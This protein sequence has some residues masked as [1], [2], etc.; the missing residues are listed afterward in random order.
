[1]IAELHI[2][3]S[4]MITLPVLIGLV[5]ALYLY[6][7]RTFDYWQKRGVKHDKPWPLF[8]TNARN[9]LMQLSTADIATETYKKYPG[10]KIVGFYRSSRPELVIRDPALAKRILTNDFAY[11]H[12]RGIMPAD[13]QLEPLQRNMFFG[14]DDLWRLV[15]IRM[16]PAFSSGKLKAMFPLI[17]ERTERLQNR[18]RNAAD[19][20]QAINSRDLMAR[21]TTDVIGNVGFGVLSDSLNDQ[22]TAFR[23]LGSRVIALDSIRIFKLT[24]KNI[25]P[26]LFGHLTVFN[27]LQ[28][29]VVGMVTA[30]MEQRKYEPS[31]RNDFVDQLLECR[32]KGVMTGESIVEVNAD[33]SPKKVSM[34]M[35]NELIAAHC[36][37]FFIAGFETSSAATSFTLHQLAHNPDIQRKAQEEIDR[38][39]SQYDNKLCYD[40]ISEMSY[41]KWCLEEGLRMFPSVGYLQRRCVRSYRIPDTKVT[42]EPGV[43]LTI[44]LDAYQNDPAI[45][46]EPREFRPERFD[47][48]VLTPAQKN[49]FLPFGDGPRACIGM[50]SLILFFFLFLSCEA[51]VQKHLD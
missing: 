21:Y 18:L 40:A 9:Y 36:L 41:L 24:L 44:P 15:R 3:S 8:G 33:G 20:K 35:D 6:L 11:F 31:G 45:F 7:T 46:P 47:P 22:N 23:E 32:K 30:I 37:L 16:T 10:E 49:A 28:K 2:I 50:L 26:K 38:V 12:R 48:A 1:M 51:S 19:S 5:V 25:M 4:V 17:V 43:S 29:E 14:E 42:I 39:L 13:F 27:E 34:E